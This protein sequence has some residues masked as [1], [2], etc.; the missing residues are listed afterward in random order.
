MDNE[1][2]HTL[3]HSASHVMAHA[4]MMLYPGT[5]LGIG[6]AIEDGFYYDLD[7]PGGITEEDLPRIE[8]KMNEIIRADY[9]FLREEWDKEKAREFFRA[10]GQE[11]KLALIAEIPDE[12]VGVYKSGEFVDL[13]KGP[14]I[15][16][17]GK[18]PA[19]K[20]ISLAGAYWKGIETN[21]MLQRIYGTAFFSAGEL[22]AYL[23]R[24]EEAKKRDHRKLGVQLDLFSFHPEIGP[25]LVMYHPKGAML[26]DLIADFSKKEHLRRGYQLVRGPHI[27]KSD[28]WI[29]SG[30]YDFYKE[31][32]F[33]FEIEGSEYAVKPMNCPGH[34][35]VY[36]SRLR[37]YRD[38]P[39]RLFELGNVYR[40][41][42]SGVLHG[43]LRVRGF[44]QDDAHIFCL[45]EQVVEE[46][47][48]VV[49]FVFDVLR[50]FGFDEYGIEISTRPEKSIGTDRQWEK[51]TNALKEA[52]NQKGV[53]YEVMEGEGAFYGPKIDIKLKDAL[54]R[55]WQCATIQCDFALP[56]RF[57]LTYIGSD[58]AEH[59]P[60]MIHRAMLGSIERFMG[61][62]IEHHA[63]AFPLWLAPTQ[64]VIIPISE[65]HRDY[66]MEIL[67]ALREH[68]IRAE[69][70]DR[71]EKMQYKIREAQVAK[72]PY[73]AIAGDKEREARSVA[74]RSRDKGDEGMLAL[75]A[76]IAR[77]H[78]ETAKK[79]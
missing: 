8:E 4:V 2:L 71:N 27:M 47:A 12:K 10:Q 50:V 37:S 3:R 78:T 38:F 73:M 23:T 43:M 39:I 54:G 66:G 42:K 36:K 65:K 15:E 5:R 52:L 75:S 22:E 55:L 19:V 32:M 67:K 74:V 63:G 58:G 77:I 14:H 48:N 31:N 56:D 57:D 45:E 60:I 33:I 26:R 79:S 25:G 28:I 41:E 18:I 24:L 21:K 70:D 11:Y 44:T 69:L 49:D 30:H 35:L 46:I 16:S 64:V 29:Q 72:I 59:R 62:L 17:T 51:A 61:A 68:E 20:L 9:P 13:C 34:M 6:P 7:I 1:T 76:F 53:G 40:Y